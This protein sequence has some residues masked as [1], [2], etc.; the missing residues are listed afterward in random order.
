MI[1]SK[2]VQMIELRLSGKSYE[3]IGKLF[4]VSKQRVFQLIGGDERCR[5]P[6]RGVANQKIKYVGLRNWM[7]ENSVSI[8]QLTRLIYGHGNAST[9]TNTRLKIYGSLEMPKS[10]IDKLIEI[11][12]L[13][14][15]RLFDEEKE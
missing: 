3:E 14:Y 8:A 13:S 12:G 11:T 9:Q 5:Y 15:E 4:G 7:R 2:T 6:V 1:D 10:F